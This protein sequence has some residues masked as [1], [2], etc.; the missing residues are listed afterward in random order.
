M[1]VYSILTRWQQDEIKWSRLDS[2]WTG[3]ETGT[4]DV[5]STRDVQNASYINV[6]LTRAV[7]NTCA[8]NTSKWGRY[9]NSVLAIV[10]LRTDWIEKKHECSAFKIGNTKFLRWKS[11]CVVKRNTKKCTDCTHLP[12][13]RHHSRLPV[14]VA[15]ARRSWS[16][17]I[18]LSSL[19]GQCWCGGRSFEWR[20]FCGGGGRRLTAVEGKILFGVVPFLFCQLLRVA[21]FLLWSKRF[22]VCYGHRDVVDCNF[23]RASAAPVDVSQSNRSKNKIHIVLHCTKMKEKRNG[24][25][26]SRVFGRA[27]VW[28]G[29]LLPRFFLRFG[30]TGIC[31]GQ[32]WRRTAFAVPCFT[33]CGRVFWL[34][35]K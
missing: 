11:C 25:P 19:S 34:F 10:L 27:C 14:D 28:G 2:S 1:L 33:V 29:F 31:R 12:H 30:R 22:V 8:I 32:T 21:S 18:F 3:W 16:V 23:K 17:I 6:L 35:L 13:K 9:N 20:R 7:W 5:V 24:F 26:L 15:V 4:N